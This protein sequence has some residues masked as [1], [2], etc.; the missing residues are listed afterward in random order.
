VAWATATYDDNIADG[1]LDLTDLERLVDGVGLV[2]VTAMSNVLGTLNPIE[3]LAAAIE[4]TW[5]EDRYLRAIHDDGTEI[6]IKGSGIWEIDALTASW[7]VFA[8]IN[9]ARARTVFDTAVAALERE[10]HGNLGRT[11]LMKMKRRCAR[12]HVR[13]V[14]FSGERIH[15]V[16]AEVTLL[17]R[18]RHG[19]ARGLGERDLVVT[20]R[21]IYIKQNASRVLTDGLRLVFRDRDVLIND[22]HRVLRERRFLLILQRCE[23]GLVDVVG[24]LGGR[25]ADQFNQGILQFTH[26]AGSA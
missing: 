14:V 6:G 23:D 7:A 5:R 2:S 10:L 4:T 12:T 15:G 17:G 13:A 18:E 20:H 19:F 3:R 21:H 1:T 16:L 22:L 11:V 26:N 9:P 24:N 8:G 25:A